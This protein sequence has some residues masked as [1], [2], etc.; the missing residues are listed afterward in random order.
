MSCNWDW[1]NIYSLIEITN[2]ININLVR[3]YCS[4]MGLNAVNNIK[5]KN[6]NASIFSQY[7]SIFSQYCNS[8]SQTHTRLN[9]LRKFFSIPNF[10]KKCHFNLRINILRML[11]VSQIKMF[12][13]NRTSTIDLQLL[14]SFNFSL[15]GDFEVCFLFWSSCLTIFTEKFI[16]W[17]YICMLG[18]YF[19]YSDLESMYT[20][21][22]LF[23]RL[24]YSV[25]LL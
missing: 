1:H 25:L 17:Y 10:K 6:R 16:K 5:S 8:T 23:Y 13:V 20:N 4:I 22:S 3:L 9:K 7:C 21:T 15:N 14:L 12:L 18:F 2:Q 11:P 19:L 24:I